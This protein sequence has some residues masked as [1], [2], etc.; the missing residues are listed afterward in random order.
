MPKLNPGIKPPVGRGRYFVFFLTSVF[1]PFLLLAQPT[2]TSFAPLSGP[3]GTIVTIT[4]SNFGATPSANIVYFGAARAT[5]TAA[6]A[7]SLTVT[8]PA[9]ANYEP[10][11]LSTGGFTAF[12]T[13]PF[14]VTFSDPGQFTPAAFGTS[15]PVPMGGANPAYICAKDLDGDGKTDLVATNS[16]GV[17]VFYNTGTP[18]FP[19]FT[20]LPTISNAPYT[21]VAVGAG[22]LDGDG[23]PDLVVSL[24]QS[25]SLCVYL[26]TS[27]PG[28]IPFASAVTVIASSNIINLGIPDINGDGRADI[29]TSS[30]GD[31]SVSVYVNSSTV[32]SLSFPTRKDPPFPATA[33]PYMLAAADLD[34]DGMVDIGCVDN[35]TD[36]VYLFHNTGIRGGTVAFTAASPVSTGPVDA[37][38]NPPS[39]FG[40]AAGDLDGDGKIDLV[41]TNAY[42]SSLTL[43]R[44]T[45]SPGN[46]SFTAESQRPSTF[47]MPTDVVIS[48]LDGD[49]LPDIS[50]VSQGGSSVGVYRNT[51]TGGHIVLA[52]SVNYLANTQAYWLTAADMDGDGLPDLSVVNNGT[53]SISVLIN[54]KANDLTISSFTPTS[55]ATG[56]AVRITGTS[57]TGVTGVSFGGIAA[58]SFIVVSPTTINAVVGA[59]A[60]G[61]VRVTTPTSFATKN[62]FTFNMHPQTITGFTPL[63]GSSSTVILIEATGFVSNQIQTVSFGGTP[64]SS[65]HIISDTELS[66]VVANG[67]SGTVKAMSLADTATSTALFTYTTTLP[68]GPPAVT[69]FAPLSATQGTDITIYG[70]NLSNITSVT[71]GG[72]QAQSFDIRSDNLVHAIVAGGATGDVSV[73]GGNG[74]GSY[75]GFTF[76][77]A[78]P[79][80]APPRLTGFSPQSAGSG[81][82]VNIRGYNL[83]DATVVTF[84]GFPVLSFSAVSDTMIVAAVGT[85]ATGRVKVAS[86]VGA[87]S[88]TG[89]VYIQDTTQ[90]APSGGVFQLIQFSGA[91]ANNQPRLN[92]QARNDGGISYYAVERG[93]DGSRFTVIGTV[94]ASNKTGTGHNYTFVDPSPKNGTNYY[95]LKMQDTTTHYVYSSAIA[96][97]LSA[98]STPLLAVY[99]NPV[100]YGF[101]LVGLPAAANASVFR[102]ADLSGRI[103][104][105]Q[106]VSA[107]VPQVRINVPGLPRGTYQLHWTDGT[108]TAY[109]SIL[110][111]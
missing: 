87:D 107:G 45:G 92:W 51:S 94:P 18:G 37:L 88:L 28:N 19:Q 20:Q 14:N 44:N 78:P 5:V 95:R 41:V 99:P 34:G 64:A 4:G 98:G 38:G 70:T 9:G 108:R 49:G 8:V 52:D 100:K 72:M 80:P 85:G 67:A 30:D 61:V 103:V 81:T 69:S 82:T 23:K 39:S 83:S 36:S 3:V 106:A 22:D 77:T 105:A 62:G 1:Y 86:A 79:P 15:Q 25:G 101:F 54:K 111:L 2:V 43:L 73:T 48:D 57:F 53:A 12:S 7:T 17:I 21:P 10:L 59:G 66:A 16:Q 47:P 75:P 46:I 58:N 35:N 42:Q 109:Q 24:Y 65:I 102:L 50:I 68:T 33:Y 40:L 26:N 55:G 60:S 56:T 6:S 91:V 71:F 27:T 84:G 96:L 63:T 90:T 93:I 97:Q 110:I 74:T 89:F 29:A 104:K 32:G 76:L 31:N 13:S 11:S